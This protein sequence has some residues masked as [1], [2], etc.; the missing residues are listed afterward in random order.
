[1]KSVVEF[2]KISNYQI[3]PYVIMKFRSAV[4]IKIDPSIVG[5][6]VGSKK[7]KHGIQLTTHRNKYD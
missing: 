4:A 2:I 3:I 1:M 6:G 5:G 7:F